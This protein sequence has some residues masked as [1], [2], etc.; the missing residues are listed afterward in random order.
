[1]IRVRKSGQTPQ[2]LTEDGK[3]YNGEDVYRQLLADQDGKCYICE[4]RTV[5]DYTIDHLFGQKRFPEMTRDWQN[6]HL[7]YSYCNDKKGGRHDDMLSPTAV[8]IEDEIEQRV[9]IGAKRALFAAI[10]SDEKHESTTALLNV[11]FNGRGR[12]RD[13]RE[14]RFFNYF[15]SEINAFMDL[16]ARYTMNGT[17]ELEKAIRQELDIRSEFL[18]FKYWIVKSNPTLDGKFG[19]LMRWNKD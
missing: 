7:A 9:D 1:M 10:V 17:E 14:E 6:L 3:A 4:R 19:T 16:L 12:M 18:G 13:V 15:L 2:S 8:D 5:T 11:V